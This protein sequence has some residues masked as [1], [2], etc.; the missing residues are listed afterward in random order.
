MLACRSNTAPGSRE[1]ESKAG[2]HTG[3]Q[4]SVS[5]KEQT[6][7]HAEGFFLFFKLIMQHRQGKKPKGSVQSN[8]I[9]T[10]IFPLVVPIHADSCGFICLSFEISASYVFWYHPKTM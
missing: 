9:K 8:Y 5:W 7:Q 10:N 3:K 1:G 6:Q 4:Q 2:G